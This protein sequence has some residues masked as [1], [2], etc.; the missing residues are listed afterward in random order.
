LDIMALVQLLTYV[1]V[2]QS[3]QF[4]QSRHVNL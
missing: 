1:L 2:L 4:L 3:D